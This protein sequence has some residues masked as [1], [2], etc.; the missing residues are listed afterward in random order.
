MTKQA[1][2]LTLLAETRDR[3]DRLSI[4]TTWFCVLV[5]AQQC[6]VDLAYPTGLWVDPEPQEVMLTRD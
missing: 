5:F 1:L 3:C 6:G 2:A 4:W